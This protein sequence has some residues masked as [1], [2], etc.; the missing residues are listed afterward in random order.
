MFKTEARLTTPPLHCFFF[1]KYYRMVLTK[2]VTAMTNVMVVDRDVFERAFSKY[3]P[4]AII[5]N[6]AVH[7]LANEHFYFL[8]VS[9]CF[10]M[11]NQ[12]S[13]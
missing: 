9:F 8:L 12:M 6:W 5:K 13:R 3:F 1:P 4:I 10:P 2:T 11:A 7:I